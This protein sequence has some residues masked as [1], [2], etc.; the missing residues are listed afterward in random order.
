MKWWQFEAL[1]SLFFRGAKPFNLGEG[2]FLGSQFPPTAQTMSGV[3]RAAI[4]ETEGVDWQK[5]RQ[6]QQPEIAQLIG[7]SSEDAGS[8]QFS[9]PYLF[10][11]GTRL[12]PVPLH[13]LY[14]EESKSWG[15]LRPSVAA[16]RTDQGER[17]LPEV[18]GGAQGGKPLERA[19]LD[20]DNFSRVLKEQSPQSFYKEK[21]LFQAESRTGIGRDNGKRK[22]GQGLLYFTRHIRLTPDVKLVMA[23]DGADAIAPASMLRL[24]GEG[25][26]ANVQ[27]ASS[28]ESVGQM[29][30][31]QGQCGVIV[32]LTHADFGGKPEPILPDGV[33]LMSACIGKAV[34][35]GGW[36]YQK[37]KPKALQSLVPAG[38]VFFVR[39]DLTRLGTHLGARNKFGYGEI[40][41]GSYEE[42]S[43]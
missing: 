14:N 2:G 15:R 1:D 9:G 12:Y 30:E 26:M 23:V 36:D 8:L 19:W 5:F 42:G 41:I 16:L 37:S 18:Q 32:L 21:D 7:D 34:R 13:V 4:A 31:T 20:A 10:K 38:S 39:G 35:E 43:K 3:I 11:G 24:G 29:R 6:G 25:R 27:V 28:P 17:H 22:T 40:A 33:A